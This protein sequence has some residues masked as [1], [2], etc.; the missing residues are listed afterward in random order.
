MSEAFYSMGILCILY[1]VV[2]IGYTKN[3]KAT[4]SPFWLIFGG[5]QCLIG[6]GIEKLPK[7]GIFTVQILCAV[8][9]LIFMAVEIII[10]SG[11]LTMPKKGL[12][13]IIVLGA[14][15]REGKIS[16]SLKRRLDQALSYLNANPQTI[17]VVSGGQGRNEE[18]TEALA[19]RNYLLQCG[20]EDERIIMEDKSRNTKENLENCL[21]YIKNKEQAVGI[22]TNNFHVYRAVKLAKY[23]GYKKVRSIM[24]GSDVVL[25]LNYMVREFFAVLYMY[26]RFGR[27]TQKESIDK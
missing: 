1:Y 23:V 2:I 27:K 9:L 21:A 17:A 6:A 24:A 18:T 19:M 5:L 25:F 13:V 26:V 20:V 16:G 10:L 4:F 3:L 15:I 12:P 11:M 7:W 22:V 8:M 14:C